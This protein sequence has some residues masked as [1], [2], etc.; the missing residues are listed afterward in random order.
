MV[1]SI[2]LFVK[3]IVKLRMQHKCE[4][5]TVTYLLILMTI[6]M[7]D[8]IRPLVLHEEFLKS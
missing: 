4:Y 1:D 2:V 3:A 5:K 8:V 6:L 7:L